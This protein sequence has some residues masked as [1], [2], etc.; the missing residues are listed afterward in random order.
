MLRRCAREEASIES[1]GA[2]SKRLAGGPVADA[3][4]RLATAR[5]NR[6]RAYEPADLTVSV[7]AGMPFSEL[8]R[9]LA[10]GDQILPLDPPFAESATVGGVIAT[11]S[12]GRRRRRYGTARDMVIGMRFAT[13]DGKLVSTGGMVVKNVSGLD[14]GKLMI[15]S[16][17]TLA[18]ITSVNFKVFPRPESSRTFAFRS[19][20]PPRL[21][22]APA[23]RP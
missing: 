4:Y 9:T 12:S 18:V 1:G 10:E 11:D 17:G 2:F 20:S 15:G 14:M 5:L 21:L 23:R 19:A 7:E 6:L 16:F 22:R 8:S 3:T 13:L